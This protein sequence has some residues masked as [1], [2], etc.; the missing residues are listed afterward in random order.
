M[1]IDVIEGA[2]HIL[3]WASAVSV[4]VVVVHK[5][6]RLLG[7]QARG[8]HEVALELHQLVLASWGARVQHKDDTIGVLLDGTPALLVAP[9]SRH[10]PELYIDV[11]TEDASMIGRSLLKLNDSART[12]LD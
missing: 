9:I 1:L 3:G 5:E 4:R 7:I 6:E 8:L 11:S 10:I 2:G 12:G